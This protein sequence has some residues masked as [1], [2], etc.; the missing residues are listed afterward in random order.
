MDLYSYFQSRDQSQDAT[1]VLPLEVKGA[2]RADLPAYFAARGFTTGAEIGVW[3][4]EHAERLCLG[5]PGLHLLCVDTWNDYPGYR[6]TERYKRRATR[7]IPSLHGETGYGRPYAA[8]RARLAPYDCQ[9]IQALS[10]EAAA[11]IPDRSLD[12]VYIDGNHQFEYV[13]ADLAA[14]TP[15]VKS[16]GVIA[17]HDYSHWGH[18]HVMQVVEAVEGWTRAYDIRPWF[19]LGRRRYR[20]G[21]PTERQRSFLWINP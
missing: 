11:Q 15:K 12:F 4:G 18:S 10:V 19:V 20:R 21:E 2:V 6:E 14:W 8:A 5:V 7:T 13:V 16:G 9:F 3:Q 1:A 17:G